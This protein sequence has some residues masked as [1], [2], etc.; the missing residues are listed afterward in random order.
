[1]PDLRISPRYGYEKYDSGLLGD[2]ID[3]FED[4]L[5]NWLFEPAKALLDFRN[6]DVASLYLLIGYFEPHAIYRKGQDSQGHSKAFFC[7]GFVEVFCKTGYSEPRIRSV[8]AALYEDVRCGLFHG[9]MLRE[10]IFLAR[11]RE[12]GQALWLT[13]PR[14]NGEIDKNGEIESMVIDV[15][16]FSSEIEQHAAAYVKLLRDAK[17]TAL[18]ENFKKAVDLTWGVNETGRSIGM[19]PEEWDRRFR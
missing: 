16:A 13:L 10:R 9:G 18:R 4:R 12:A 15:P 7:D 11:A 14:V 3:V 2:L 1:M 17:N 5:Q 19:S 8:A 6:G